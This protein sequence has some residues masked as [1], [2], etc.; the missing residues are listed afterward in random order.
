MPTSFRWPLAVGLL[1]FLLGVPSGADAQPTP[2]NLK[3]RSG[4]TVQPIFEGWSRNPGGGFTMHFGYF[5]RNFVEEVH[6]PV[7]QDN[8]FEPGEIDAGQPT[9]FYPRAHRRSFSVS[10]PRDFGDQ[11][12]VWNLTVRGETLRAVGRLE[13]TWETAE[14]AAGTRRISDEAAANTAPTIA[15]DTPSGVTVQSAVTLS[16]RV[17]DDRLPVRRD[18][19]DGDRAPGNNDPPTLEAAPDSP[20]PPHNVPAVP[21]RRGGARDGPRIR[22]LRVSWIVWRGPVGVTFEPSSTVEVKDGQ[23][24]ATATFT[25]PGDYVLR[26]EANDD[27]LTTQYELTVTVR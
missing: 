27:A 2:Y 20:E 23:A 26:A 17:T 4:Q 16:A 13:A 22:G 25:T 21:D 24:V 1:G 12:L 3:Y 8:R 15:V 6:V 14:R 5:N 19:D 11:Q 7:G 9:F 18:I 10:V